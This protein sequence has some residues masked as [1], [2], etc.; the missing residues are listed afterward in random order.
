MR[1]DQTKKFCDL[2]QDDTVSV[3]HKALSHNELGIFRVT[4][5]LTL[6]TAN[7]LLTN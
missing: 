4:I 5:S 2:F 6:K 7:Y 1:P 3:E